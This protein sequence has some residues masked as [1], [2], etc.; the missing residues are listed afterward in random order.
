MPSS[1]LDIELSKYWEQL[2][3]AQKHSLLNII[4]TFFDQE[5]DTLKQTNELQDPEAK[6]NLPWEIFKPLNKQQKKA[7]IAFLQSSGI[8]PAGRISIEQ[9]N[10]ELEEAETEIEKGEFYTHE[11][12]HG[13]IKKRFRGK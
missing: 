10:K 4:K 6:Y 5:V 7:L 8:E 13:M 3:P 11:E 12:V 1:P 2:T 9:Y